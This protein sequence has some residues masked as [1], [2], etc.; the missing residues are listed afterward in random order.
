VKPSIIDQLPAADRAW[1]ENLIRERNF[2]GYREIEDLAKDRG[3]QVDH[4]QIWRHAQKI[5]RTIQMVQATVDVAQH[6]GETLGEDAA[7]AL[8]AANIG[9]A[10]SL[11]YQLLQQLTD[12]DSDASVSE[13]S[14]LLSS[15]AQLSRASVNQKQWAAK[16]RER[17]D[18]KLKTLEKEASGPARTLDPATLKRVREEIYGL[19]G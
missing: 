19:V 8:S 1:L 12:P 2:S 3:L 14:K 18:E 4:V 11:V 16:V 10:Q 9:M 6:L 15:L 13:C 5:R 17:M 7:D